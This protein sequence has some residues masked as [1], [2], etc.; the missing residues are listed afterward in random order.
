MTKKVRQLS[1]KEYL[2]PAN[3]DDLHY[4]AERG[5]NFAEQHVAA[6]AVG[7]LEMPVWILDGLAAALGYDDEDELMLLDPLGTGK[8][9]DGNPLKPGVANLTIPMRDGSDVVIE[10]A[11]APE[12]TW[13][14]AVQLQF[15]EE[16]IR[17]FAGRLRPV[18]RIDTP[19]LYIVSQVLPAGFVVDDI[20]STADLIPSYA[21]LIDAARHT[22]GILDHV[23]CH[24]AR[25]DLASKDKY[26]DL[27]A[28]LPEQLKAGYWAIQYRVGESIRIAGVPAHHGNPT[29][30]LED[31]LER[32]CIAYS[33]I[34]ILR[35]PANPR[36]APADTRPSDEIEVALGS[37]EDRYASECAALDRAVEWMGARHRN[38]TRRPQYLPGGGSY[39]VGMDKDSRPIR[40]GLNAIA[41]LTRP[42]DEKKDAPDLVAANDDHEIAI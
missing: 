2:A 27:F 28:S 15:R 1:R 19:I 14:R 12:G 25:P 35:A 16:S 3:V 20:V 26:R 34:E 37:R 5:L 32:Q 21:P 29:R 8:D 11:M 40:L 24:D 38:D 9:R 41:L 4:G 22:D 6:L 36:R 13:Q 42:K 31:L 10:S 18:Y 23:R 17:Q 39:V 30:V 7:R 33:D